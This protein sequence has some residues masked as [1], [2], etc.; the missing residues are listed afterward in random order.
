[1]SERTFSK[2]NMIFNSQDLLDH[3]QQHGAQIHT[4]F[5]SLQPIENAGWGLVAACDVPAETDLFHIPTPL[6]LSPT[7]SDLRHHLSP[8]EIDSLD[9]GWTLLIL[10]MMWE[11]SRGDASPWAAYLRECL[12]QLGLTGR[13]HAR[14]VLHPHVLVG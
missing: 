9:H 12:V 3:L 10:S 7:T 4:R 6:V 2:C 1:M 8:S 14:F 5:F 13:K 11:M